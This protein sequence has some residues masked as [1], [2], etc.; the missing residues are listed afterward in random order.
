ME[1]G[2]PVVAY[3]AAALPE[4]VAD[5]G[6]LLDDKDPLAVAVSVGELLGDPAR[7]EHQRSAGRVRAEAF[8]LPRSSARLLELVHQQLA[9]P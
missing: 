3:A 6:L 2:L 5:G 4:T 8:C 7:L 9:T 1:L